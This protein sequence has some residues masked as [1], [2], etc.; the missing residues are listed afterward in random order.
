MKTADFCTSLKKKKKK[1]QKK[2]KKTKKKNYRSQNFSCLS[3]TL[4]FYDKQIIF[5]EPM[6]WILNHK[7]GKI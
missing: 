5:S 4:Y 1:Q 6:L 2:K 3:M 7:L